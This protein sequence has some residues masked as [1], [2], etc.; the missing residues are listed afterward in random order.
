[1]SYQSVPDSQQWDAVFERLAPSELPRALGACIFAGGFTFGVERAGFQIA[2]HLELPDLTLGAC[3]SRQRWPV[4]VEPASTH[5]QNS[6]G[7]AKTWLHRAK[8][9]RLT[10]RVPDFLYCNPP[11]VAYAMNGKHGGLKDDRMC[12]VHYCVNLLA[13]ELK[14]TVWA[15]ELVPGITRDREYLEELAL[16]AREQGYQCWGFLTSSAL[17][18]A[19]QARERFHFVA[20][21]VE[22]N[23]VAAYEREPIERK[24]YQTL[25]AAL[26]LVAREAEKGPL[27]NHPFDQTTGFS[28]LIPYLAPGVTFGRMPP[29][30]WQQHFKPADGHVWDPSKGDKPSGFSCIR[31]LWGKPCPNIIGGANVVH[32]I[33]DRW[34]TPR[35]AATVMGFPLNYAFTPNGVAY[36]EI[37][38]GLCTHN[39]E[40][41]ARVVRHGLELDQGVD[42]AKREPLEWV[43]LRP[44]IS[45]KEVKRSLFKDEIKEWWQSRHAE[46]PCPY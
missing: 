38:K 45:R 1:M 12:Y 15:W 4:V 19:Y 9:L 35:E 37:G 36:K 18:H 24:G 29:S 5:T 42:L 2:G 22:L 21:K 20:S 6:V 39:A 34:L 26:E 8:E 10:K 31:G 16:N 27:P 43:D 13:A 40:F 14:P 28:P 44:L 11:C 23:F 46:L 33:E 3:V 17:H 32:P 25:G 7:F 41:L 30:L